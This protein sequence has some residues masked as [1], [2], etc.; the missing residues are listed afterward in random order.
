MTKW[1]ALGLLVAARPVLAQD[2]HY[3]TESYGTYATLLGGVVVGKV[4]DLSA[5]FY[6]PGRLA[7]VERPAISLTTRIYQV[8][9]RQLD[10][11]G[12]RYGQNELGNTGV[13]PAPSFAGGVLPL[14]GDKGWVLAYSVV[15]RQSDD[16][17]IDGSDTLTGPPFSGAQL[18]W[19][20]KA[21][22]SWYGL[23][24]SRKVWSR[25][26]VG[27]TLFGAYRSQSQRTE[28]H[29]QVNGAPPTTTSNI[30]DY[31][32]WDFRLLAKLGISTQLGPWFLGGAVTSPGLSIMG[33]GEMLTT[34]VSTGTPALFAFRGQE[35][36]D[37]DYRGTWS[38][39]GGVARTWGRVTG[40]ASAEW[41][42]P[43][44]RYT[45]L[46]ADSILPQDGRP[47][48]DD[49]VYF[50]RAEVFN[51][52]AGVEVRQSASRAIYA[53]YKVD[54]SARPTGSAV[55]VTFERWG[56][57]HMGGGYAFRLGQWDLVAGLSYSW[58]G[59][60]FVAGEADAPPPGIPLP[61]GASAKISD[62]RLKVLFG[63]SV[64]F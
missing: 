64:R 51:W 17:I 31:S 32:Y 33:G 54:R 41:F 19:D 61:P 43:V 9:S 45:L 26:G 11:S 50:E 18:Y 34:Q 30:R 46:D 52:G 6:N 10:L 49:D 57:H 8:V 5:A 58:G 2:A 40:Y 56:R 20:R 22:E 38:V 35:E 39:S 13:R 44:G 36:L 47:A 15:T 3:W 1:I 16:E 63:F 53:H 27:L 37:P 28:L 62:H 23:S 25:T 55:D 14:A 4:P 60:T 12:I 24:A 7:F 42:A 59:D 48:Y 29:G 21:S